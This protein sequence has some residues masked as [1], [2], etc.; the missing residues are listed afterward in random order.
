MLEINGKKFHPQSAPNTT[1]IIYEIKS[2]PEPEI[3]SLHDSSS[4]E[5]DNTVL[6]LQR[7]IAYLDSL[8]F[9]SNI[10][11][12]GTKNLITCI[13]VYLYSG[14]QHAIIHVDNKGKLD[15]TEIL[16]K[17]NR[18]EK[19][20][21]TLIGGDPSTQNNT[22]LSNR[23]LENIVA[24][25]LEA[26]GSLGH[27]LTITNQKLLEKNC[28]SENKYQFVFDIIHS[29]ADILYRELFNES[30][31]DEVFK[32]FTVM[33]LCPQTEENNTI[34]SSPQFPQEHLSQLSFELILARESYGFSSKLTKNWLPLFR[35]SN[36]TKIDFINN[37]EQLFC[38]ECFQMIDQTSSQLISPTIASRLKNF[39]FDITTKKI[40]IVSKH[41]KTFNENI[42][43]LLIYDENQPIDYFKCY[44]GKW[45]E[46]KLS[47]NFLET[48]N[49]TYNQIKNDGKAKTG[50]FAKIESSSDV[51][52]ANEILKNIKLTLDKESIGKI[53]I[54]TT[55]SFFN[56][57][58]KETAHDQLLLQNNEIIK[59]KVGD[60]TTT[61]S[62]H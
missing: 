11:Y 50:C 53:N 33:D 54:N 30:L 55:S 40:H 31:P 16:S 35:S 46:H 17:F 6:C 20:E 1:E 57:N 62:W 39:V 49:S 43:C 42:R 8:N 56:A 34:S 15:F 61:P 10:R 48:C 9:D 29:R 26:I 14:T 47:K 18:D 58:S 25:L 44:N 24:M 3:A 32:K 12:I 41:M 37:I 52:G 28:C 27:T 60:Q 59:E 5:A 22:D 23:N 2:L 7:E 38:N 13:L 45:N 19:I 51:E 4:I 36:Q 21:V